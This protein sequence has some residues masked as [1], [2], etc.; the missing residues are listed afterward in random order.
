M[1]LKGLIMSF[2]LAVVVLCVVCVICCV[3]SVCL[4]F[5]HLSMAIEDTGH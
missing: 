1:E 5:V 4:M 3:M 2:E